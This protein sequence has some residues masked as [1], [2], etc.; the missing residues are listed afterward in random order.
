MQGINSPVMKAMYFKQSF[1]FL[2]QKLDEVYK[3]EQFVLD[4]IGK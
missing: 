1:L 3:K 4:V 2:V